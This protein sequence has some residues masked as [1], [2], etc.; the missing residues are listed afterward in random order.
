M[1]AA[2]AGI[3]RSPLERALG[4]MF[5]TK[6]A[7]DDARYFEG[8]SALHMLFVLT[9]LDIVF[10][11]R[12]GTVSEIHERVAP[13]RP[14]VVAREGYSALELAPG[15]AAAADIRLGDTLRFV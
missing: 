4:F 3:A 15:R 9:P 12:D 11:E 8:C 10:L 14:A 5:F 7:E 2:R 1:V 6:I 13:F